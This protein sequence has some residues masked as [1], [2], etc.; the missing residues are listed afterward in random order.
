[1]IISQDITDAIEKVAPLSL[2]YE[3]DNCGLLVGSRQKE[4]KK[5]LTCLDCDMQVVEEAQSLKADMILSHHPFFFYDKKRYTEDDYYMRVLKKMFQW[6]INYYAAHTN[7]D[8]ASG[9]INDLLAQKI[10]LPASYVDVLEKTDENNGL[11]RVY[12]LPSPISM[13]ALCQQ[14]KQ[15][16]KAEH[17]AFTG[18]K[19][20]L[21][22][23]I[24]LCS[25]GGQGFADFALQKK[26]DVYIT[27]DFRHDPAKEYLRQN[28]SLILVRHYD[29]EIIIKEIYHKIL[30]DAFGE[31]I[32]VFAS[33]VEKPIFQTFH[34]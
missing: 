12:Q 19:Q 25:G 14:I 8:A 18:D 10:G 26:C 7:M 11:G 31:Q 17:I 29:S 32:E 28:M 20:K 30:K 3:W 33:Q 1:M 16:L 34:N 24:G 13:A 21:V 6:D 2:A 15:G 5:V 4:I 27:G 22:Q 9:G 23:T